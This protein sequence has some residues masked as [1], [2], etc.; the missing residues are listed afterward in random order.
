ME[1]EKKIEQRRQYMRSYYQ[2]K[3]KERIETGKP[4]APKNKKLKNPPKFSIKRG[5]FIVSFN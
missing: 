2:R 3:K 4:L 5:E 1:E